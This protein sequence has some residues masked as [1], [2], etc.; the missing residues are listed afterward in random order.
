MSPE[1][2]QPGDRMGPYL[3]QCRI[4][5]GGM[6]EVFE[7]TRAD[8][9]LARTVAVKL[10][11]C[12]WDGD[13]ASL[14]RRFLA[15]RQILAVLNHPN[16]ARLLDGGVTDAGSQYVVMELVHGLTLEDHVLRRQP[17]LADRLK[18]FLELCDA[19]HY[20][21]RHLIVHRDLKPAN[22][23]VADDGHVKLLD[24]GI[25][26]FLRPEFWRGVGGLVTLPADRLATPEY[27]APEQLCGEP[28]TTSSDVYSLGVI[29][30]YLLSGR[31]PYNVANKN[32]HE[33]EHTVNQAAPQPLNTFDGPAI[34]RDLE[35]IALTALR[36]EPSGRYSSVE[37]MA[38]DLR[39]HLNGHPVRARRGEWF[40]PAS[41]FLRRHAA[42]SAM[43][44]ALMAV[45][46]AAVW[47][48]TKQARMLAVERDTAKATADFL[49]DLFDAADPNAG[50]GPRT[51][52]RVLDEGARRLGTDLKDQPRVRAALAEKLGDVYRQLSLY[53]EAQ[54]LAEEAL[55]LF[56]RLDGPESLDAARNM[57]RLADL[58]RETQKYDRAEKLARRALEIRTTRLGRRHADVADSLNILGILCQI[59]G[60]A[61][62]AEAAFAEA[63]DIR[64]EMLPPF[65]PLL[66]LSLGN[67]GNMLRE[68][69]DYDGAYLRF[70]EA[71]AI[72]RKVWGEWHPRVASSLGQLSQISL[73]RKDARQALEL[74]TQALAIIR[75]ALPAGHPDIART[76][77]AHGNALRESGKKA[78]AESVFREALATQRKSR[79]PEAPETAFAAIALAKLLD[80]NGKSAEAE[81]LLRSSL[82]ARRKSLGLQ[83][84][85]V[86]GALQE[87]AAVLQRRPASQDEARRLLE[88]A[89]EIRVRAQ[90][91]NHREAEAIRARLAKPQL[92]ASGR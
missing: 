32:W 78:E 60:H 25:A 75:K 51:V 20:A 86:A 63:V 62:E 79:G 58:L 90:G 89:L 31:L 83:H 18:L 36:K 88:Q 91:W 8:G 52:R 14:E 1:R 46:G 7:A 68:R 5:C 17:A 82:A 85:L 28:V 92:L 56:E 3:L 87:L 29:F 43:A 35:A 49:G 22:V 38:E 23:M 73:A 33:I 13:T 34:S 44:A 59:G 74:T 71:L 19:V 16:I 72:R 77:S 30:Y 9:V 39:R 26:K 61:R 11:R 2:F 42:M 55:R 4:G 10:L 57:V 15:E 54:P 80:G 84:P 21:H 67:L 66:A 81:Q 12:A 76:L 24:F 69:G 70:S 65:D 48:N 53:A 45:A 40:Y 47:T 6:A 37:H 27:A 41:K 64:R 50:S